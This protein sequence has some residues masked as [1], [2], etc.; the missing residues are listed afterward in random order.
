MNAFARLRALLFVVPLLT[1]AT[2]AAASKPFISACQ[3]KFPELF[4]HLTSDELMLA[5]ADER[6]TRCAIEALGALPEGIAAM[7]ALLSSPLALVRAHAAA[8]LGMHFDRGLP[9]V[10][11]LIRALDDAD[12]TV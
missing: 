1:S 12:E 4:S 3:Q 8:N 5:A 10:P 11:A 6:R 2:A 7:R 9:A